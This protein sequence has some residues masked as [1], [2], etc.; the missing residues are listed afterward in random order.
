MM[1]NRI[2]V[3]TALTVLTFVGLLLVPQAVTPLKN[4][5]SI[6]PKSVA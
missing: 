1:P 2:P 3:K 6:E 5:K 4:Y